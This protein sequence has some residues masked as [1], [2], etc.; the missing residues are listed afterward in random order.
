MGAHDAP[1]PPGWTT[2]RLRECS[3]DRQ[4]CA[5]PLDFEVTD[6]TGPVAEP[7]TPTCILGF[8]ALCIVQEAETGDWLMGSRDVDART[9]QCWSN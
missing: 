8:S 3:G 9:A 2:E 1:L 5:L 4:A 6:V 7:I